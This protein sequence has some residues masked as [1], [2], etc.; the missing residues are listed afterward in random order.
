MKIKSE[1]DGMKKQNYLARER[2]V[3]L[4]G[5]HIDKAG[6]RHFGALNILGP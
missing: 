4:V 5:G 1:L 6:S 2:G 3:W